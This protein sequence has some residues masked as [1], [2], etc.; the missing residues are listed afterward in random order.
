MPV[1]LCGCETWLCTLREEHR[2][3][4]FDSR[5]LKRI[6]GP[7]SEGVTGV[8]KRLN[9]EKLNDLYCS[10]NIIWISK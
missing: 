8:W 6:F 3:R 1:M 2:L 4:V 7:K 10:Q 5:V 9:N